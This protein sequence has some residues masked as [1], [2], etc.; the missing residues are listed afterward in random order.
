MKYLFYLT[1]VLLLSACAAKPEIIQRIPFN[2]TE[3]ADLPS[4]GTATVMGQAF[5]A[6]AD[7]IQHYPQNEHARLNPVTSYSRQWY[8]VNYLAKKNIAD[9]DPRYLE[10][11]YKVEF[12]GQGRFRFHNIPAGDYYISAPIFWMQEIKM[13][14]G[15]ILMKRQGMFICKELHVDE[16]KTVVTE[17]TAK[18][19]VNMASSN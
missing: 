7:G 8:E 13:A 15:S 9:A 19:A 14:D 2:P 16:G 12:D 11:V 1:G 6:G 18:H 5:V 10:Y 4:S 3:F 17:I